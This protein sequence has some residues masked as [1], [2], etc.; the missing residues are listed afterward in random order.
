MAFNGYLIKANG[1]ELNNSILAQNG[2]SS[3]PNMLTDKD[4]YTDGDGELHRTVLPHTRSKIY[5]KTTELTVD[6]KKHLQTVFPNRKLI[7]VEYWNDEDEEYSTGQFYI[8]D[9]KW[10]I[11]RIDASTNERIYDAVDITLIEY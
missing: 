8:P 7:N 5:I 4:S 9:I 1:I 11:K 6:D 10:S 3:N 2:Y